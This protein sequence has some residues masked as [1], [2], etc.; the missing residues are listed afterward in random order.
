MLSGYSEGS[1]NYLKKTQMMPIGSKYKL[2][3]PYEIAYGAAGSGK[4]P[5]GAML[6]FEIELL[7]IKKKQ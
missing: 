1:K 6:T 5:G 2:Y 7:D 4:I 3:I